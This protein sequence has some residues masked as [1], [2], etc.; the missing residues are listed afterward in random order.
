MFNWGR[1]LGRIWDKNFKTFLACYSQSALLAN[2][3][4][5][6]WFSWTWDF[7]SLDLGFRK[8]ENLIENHIPLWFQK[9]IQ[10]NQ[11]MKKIQIC[12]LSGFCRNPKPKVET[13]NQKISTLCPETSSKLHFH[14]FGLWTIFSGFFLEGDLFKAWFTLAKIL[15]LVPLH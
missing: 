8:E 9:S 4:P 14:E 13:W 2:F 15:T 11:S 12:S 10:N 1:I 7:H 3:P 5:Q 6:L